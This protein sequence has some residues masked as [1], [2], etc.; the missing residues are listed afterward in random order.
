MLRVTHTHTHTHTHTFMYTDI[1]IYVYINIYTHTN[2]DAEAETET[3]EEG[4]RVIGGQGDR[5]LVELDVPL[6]PRQRQPSLSPYARQHTSAYVRNVS[7]R[8]SAR[9]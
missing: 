8:V 5:D 3:F 4:R 7:I 1:Y 2:A 9:I 6:A